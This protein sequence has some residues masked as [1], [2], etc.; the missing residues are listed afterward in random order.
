MKSLKN[1]FLNLGYEFFK[2]GITGVLNTFITLTLIFLFSYVYGF[3]YLFSNAIGYTM[4][5]LNSFFLNKYW[6][7]KSKGSTFKQFLLFL[8]VF[9][10]CY[11]IQ[12]LFLFYFQEFLNLKEEFSQFFSMIIYTVAN[13]L[14]NKFWTFK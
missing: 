14:F 13:F 2:F 3:H 5:F 4:G 8:K 10:I 6:T 1:I 11:G 9:L 12:F 7:F